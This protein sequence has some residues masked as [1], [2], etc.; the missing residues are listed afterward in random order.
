MVEGTVPAAQASLAAQALE[1]ALE[2]KPE[3]Q[4]AQVL[5]PSA[6]A[7]VLAAQLVQALAPSLTV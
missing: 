5:A 6:G 3:A 7:K 2:K 4:A 1:P